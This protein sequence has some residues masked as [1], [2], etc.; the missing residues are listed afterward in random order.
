MGI[1]AGVYYYSVDISVGFLNFV[2]QIALM[3]R[4]VKAHL[5]SARGAEVLNFPAEV[6]IGRA[7]VDFRLA[8]AE[9]IEIRSVY[10][11]YFHFPA[12]FLI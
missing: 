11:Q 1:G 2:Y 3:V 9:H 12:A 7:A 8:D 4:L 6:G 5:C 10:N